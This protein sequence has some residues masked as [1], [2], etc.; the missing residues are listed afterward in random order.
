MATIVKKIDD[1]IILESYY[2]WEKDYEAN[3]N[4]ESLS[5]LSSL[6]REIIGEWYEKYGCD[7]LYVI[8]GVGAKFDCNNNSLE[9]VGRLLYEI[10]SWYNS[11]HRE[12]IMNAQEMINYLQDYIREESANKDDIKK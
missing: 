5:D 7:N 3:Y 6:I 9:K 2:D 12:N 11:L 1:A 4:N 8:K 10:Q